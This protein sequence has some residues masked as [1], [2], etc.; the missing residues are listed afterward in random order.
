[1]FKEAFPPLAH[2]LE[3]RV[4]AGSNILVLHAFCGIEHDFSPATSIYDDVYFRTLDSRTALCSSVNTIINGL[5]LGITS[6]HP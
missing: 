1:M 4:Q 6:H 5:F 3:R 2:D